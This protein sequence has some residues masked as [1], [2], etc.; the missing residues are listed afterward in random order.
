MPEHVAHYRRVKVAKRK[1]G[2]AI[3]FVERYP[4]QIYHQALEWKHLVLVVSNQ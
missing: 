1:L 2:G 3:P 4:N